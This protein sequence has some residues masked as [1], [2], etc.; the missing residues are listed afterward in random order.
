MTRSPAIG[1]LTARPPAVLAGTVVFLASEVMF[2]GSLFGAYFTV[3]AA[4]DAWPPPGLELDVPRAAVATAVLLLSSLTM[5]AAVRALDTGRDAAAR[6][7]LLVT[8]LLGAAFLGNQAGE[9]R[10]AGFGPASHAFGAAFF[11]IT[12]FHGLHVLGG[13]AA[14][15]VLLG[16]AYRFTPDASDLPGAESL[17]LYWHF[18]DAVWLAVFATLFLLR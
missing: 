16:R 1:T 13:L 6:R 14:I 4:S 3:R 7:L 12:G 9:W 8:L 18:V 15:A 5:H 2:F 10:A 11:V 17:T